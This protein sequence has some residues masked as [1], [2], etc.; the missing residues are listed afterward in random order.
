MNNFLNFHDGQLMLCVLRNALSRCA[1][2]SDLHESLD[3][4]LLMGKFSRFPKTM[5]L[6]LVRAR[7]LIGGGFLMDAAFELNICHN[8]P[9][10]PELPCEL[11]NFLR[12]DLP[13][14]LFDTKEERTE[15]MIAFSQDL[16]EAKSM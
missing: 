7:T 10:D 2:P 14:Y 6:Q 16:L 9:L 13:D 11:N 8:L 1:I 5:S 4:L 15:F 12:G 3:D